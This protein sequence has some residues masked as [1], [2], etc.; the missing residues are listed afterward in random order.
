MQRKKP[1]AKA[2]PRPPADIDPEAVT[3]LAYELYLRR[4]GDHGHDKEDWLSAEQILR[5]R[6]R[7]AESG[8]RRRLEDKFST[9]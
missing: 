7:R 3:R 5:M 8:E 6:T 1:K 9:R 2:T 4:G